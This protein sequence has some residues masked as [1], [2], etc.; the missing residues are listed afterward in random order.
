MLHHWSMTDN[1]GKLLEL[2]ALNA[3]P[4][5]PRLMAIGARLTRV[6]DFAGGAEDCETMARSAPARPL[7]F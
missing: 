2:G 7:F 6:R 5:P 4:C 1:I 3:H